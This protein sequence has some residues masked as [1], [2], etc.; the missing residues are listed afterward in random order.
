MKK[1]AYIINVVYGLTVSSIIAMEVKKDDIV[2]RNTM[3]QLS[4]SCFWMNS[5]DS[6][7]DRCTI[8]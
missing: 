5:I 2:Q 6:R 3:N 4:S 8:V 1:V 7:E